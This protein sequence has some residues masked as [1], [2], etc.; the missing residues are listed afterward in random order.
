MSA[1]PRNSGSLKD[2]KH[3]GIHVSTGQVDTAAE[4]AA[5]FTG[6]LDEAESIRIRWVAVSSSSVKVTNDDSVDATGGR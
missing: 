2:E 5:G 4:V 1:S 3:Q 6:V